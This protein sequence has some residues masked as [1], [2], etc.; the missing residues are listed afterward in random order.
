MENF[1]DESILAR[2]DLENEC[3]KMYVEN[4]HTESDNKKRSSQKK[5]SYGDIKEG[6]SCKIA[7]D[8]G[9]GKA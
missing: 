9:K 8:K 3:A 5:S 7:V 6:L 4:D 1:D 2:E